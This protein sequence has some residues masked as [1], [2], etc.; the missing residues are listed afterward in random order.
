MLRGWRPP[1]PL[2]IA[3]LATCVALVTTACGEESAKR[4]GP[5]DRQ[6]KRDR[7]VDAS[8]EPKA[9]P[10][11]DA[12]AKPSRPASVPANAKR[13]RVTGIDDGDTVDLAGLSSSRLIGI[14]T[15]EVYFG[16]ECFGA[17]ASAFTKQVL[18]VGTHVFYTRGIE[19]IDRYDRDLV[20][21]WLRDGTFFN[22]L[23]AK[24]GYA[25]PL[26]IAPNDRYAALFA[27]LARA[28]A[29][30]KRGLWAR[31]TCNGD[32]DLPAE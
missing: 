15:P 24:R 22:A 12:Q 4:Q 27:R 20:Y 29:S 17:A 5:G 26:T 32:P 16:A 25:V 30:A 6:A 13:T 23:L 19:P 10:E 18:P 14:D 31:T 11:Q 28:A 9:E 7:Q 1:R 8:K 21:V 3:A 2:A